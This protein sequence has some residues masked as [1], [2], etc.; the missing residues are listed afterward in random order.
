MV[1]HRGNYGGGCLAVNAV[2]TELGKIIEKSKEA[3]YSIVLT[4]DHGNCEEMQDDKGNR[5]T[6]HTVGN[7]WCYVLDEKVGKLQEGGGLN[8]VAPTVLKM[9]GLSIPDEMDKALF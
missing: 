6:N 2:D 4:S 5:L 9:M 8:N 7:V 1:G 3:N